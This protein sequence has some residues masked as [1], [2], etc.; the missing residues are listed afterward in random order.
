MSNEQNTPT[1]TPSTSPTPESVK[2]YNPFLENVSEK[3]YTRTY[4]YS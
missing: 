3:P 4:V 1:P 2:S